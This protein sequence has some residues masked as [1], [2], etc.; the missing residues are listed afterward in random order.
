MELPTACPAK[1][2]T[3]HSLATSTKTNSTAG[4]GGIGFLMRTI[5]NSDSF[6]RLLVLRRFQPP[7]IRGDFAGLVDVVAAAGFQHL[8][9]DDLAGFVQCQ[10][11][12]ECDGLAQVEH[13]GFAGQA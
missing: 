9:A 10:C 8:N 12:Y 1:T 6:P 11:E 13:V 4:V 7:L 5:R 2:E 3:I